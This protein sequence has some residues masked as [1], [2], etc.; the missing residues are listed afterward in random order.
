MQVL[1]DK[2]RKL[3]RKELVPERPSSEAT[4][5][6][7]GR[8]KRY[9]LSLLNQVV[10]PDDS[11]GHHMEVDII[12]IHGLNGDAYTTWEHENGTLWLRDLLPHA[13]PGSRIFTYGYP[14]EVFC[15]NSAA[16]LRDYSRNLLISL[17]SISEKQQRPLIFVCHSLGGIVCKQAL[18]LAHEDNHLY[19]QILSATSAIIFFGTPHRGSKGADIGKVVARTINL[20]LRVSQTSRIAGPIRDDLLITL[21]SN[22]QELS[23]LAV[24]SRNRMRNLEVVTFHETE[25][26]PGLS[27]LIVDQQSAIME[28]PG[29]DII[30][31]YANH[32]TMCRFHGPTDDNYRYTLRAIQRLVK[33]ALLN[34]DLARQVDSTSSNQSF[35]EI[36]RACMVLLNSIYLI[37]YRAELPKPVQGT[38]NWVL[39]DPLF[40]TWVTT[41]GTKLLW[42]TGEP[43]CGKTMLS[44][45]LIEHL[46]LGHAPSVKPRVF[47]FFCDDKVRYQRDG[48]AILRGILYQ[49]LQQHRKLIKH[50]KNRF[51]IDGPSLANSFPALWELFLKVVADSTLGPIEIILDAVDECETKTRNSLLNALAQLIKGRG[52]AYG[53]SDNY[54]KF[55]ITSRP[56]F[57]SS[58]SFGELM[59]HRICIER[60][61]S[62]ISGD[63][64][65]VI[66]SKVH[67]IAERFHCDE[68]TKNYLEEAL[69]SK[70]DQSFLWLN[71]VLHSLEKSSKASKR[72]FERIINT[73]PQDL[74]KTYSKLL[75]E[76][77]PADRNDAG[78]V[79]RL[80]VGSS[81]RL[82][83]TEMN[84]A[85]TV[86]AIHR[87]V[88][89]LLD[90]L[91]LSIDATL[92]SLVGSFIRI[93]QV[94][95]P[96]YGDSKISLI[97]QSAKEYLT[98]F[99]PRSPV[100]MI[101]SLAAPL[102][103]AALSISESCITYL[104]LDDFQLDIF[105]P[106]RTSFELS[107]PETSSP[108]S[109][110]SSPLDEP[111]PSALFGLDDD[112]GL[113]S[114]F[115]DSQNVNEEKCAQIAQEYRFFDYS[116][117][118]WA[119][120][121]SLCESIAPK[122]I[123]DAA[124][125]LT[126]CSNHL[127]KNWLK[128]Y[129]TKR[130]MEYSFPERFTRIELAA[131]FNLPVLL[132]DTLE[133]AEVDSKESIERALFWAARKCSID[134]IR[135]LLRFNASPNSIGID[136]QTPLTVSAQY[137]HLDAVQILLNEKR[138]DITLKGR[139]GRSALSFAAG[140]GHLDI[141]EALLRH[142][143]FS[144]DDR[145]NEQWSPIFWAVQ[146]DFT[147]IVKLLLRQRSLNINQ[148]DIT[149]RSVLSWAAG[150]G[151]RGTLKALL[152]HPS[153]N[154]NLKDS[155]GR[156][157]LS[158]AAGNGQSEAVRILLCQNTV[159]KA[160]KDND[161]RNVI[162][163]ACQGGH[164]DTLRIL[165]KNG[166]DGVDDLDADVWTPLL[167]AL[168]TQSPTTVE[169][170]L[171]TRRVQID[172][173]DSYGRTALIWAASY[174]YLDVVKL[175]VTWK[176]D[177]HVKNHRGET[178][179]DA[180]KLEGQIEVWEF[181]KAQES[182]EPSA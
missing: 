49:I 180:A 147:D 151:C 40:R 92:E 19:G 83:L 109:L 26:M 55:L 172:R 9:G 165:L 18:V 136:R 85:F 105:A 114:F 110:H 179:A 3:K 150:E 112:L 35:T 88:A 142:D 119:E 53:Q 149:G 94:K 72:D 5:P 111:S 137:G 13:L 91:Q 166:C 95:E 8:T 177:L 65:L 59:R 28:M 134:C 169:V 64:K 122:H 39:T 120:H 106:R 145:D 34:Q 90:D 176:A 101:R 171:S 157:P 24:S 2:L 78:K 6:V 182:G 128:Y 131:F 44:T 162:S 103:H 4:A 118:H 130:N 63:V 52:D 143:A 155:K 36:E 152:R 1:R 22:S 97:H 113:D 30:P 148:A 98:E 7:I 23:D 170:L 33:K 32:R 124:F 38:C 37:E 75:S 11:K 178:A 82:T 68:A 158:W 14:S 62:N 41:E 51:D 45:Y 56:S 70:S 77:P 163:W 129:W 121:Y 167:W 25:T 84:V 86:D 126:E 107:S 31:L 46:T 12:A 123:R 141:V 100:S 69:Y 27:E 87:S 168:F 99:A 139:S 133:K 164:T 50:V 21:G 140:N 76:I 104:L 73:F 61:Q 127:V 81:R 29:E 93:K 117:S 173:R 43:G 42:I 60:N 181:L 108:E 67:E 174:G 175:L 135:I 15:S 66:R 58:H 159:D 96:S 57:R 10:P 154:P 20:C 146:G 16:K 161:L 89:D 74:E 160:T 102:S 17:N 125:Q 153:I 144:C 80:L 71:M 48:N 132:V 156:S 115:G 116:A 47:Y 138:T 79:L 54:I